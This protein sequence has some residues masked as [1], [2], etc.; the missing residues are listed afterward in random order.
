MFQLPAAEFWEALAEVVAFTA[1]S[2]LIRA[3]GFG[4][5]FRVFNF[6]YSSEILEKPRPAGNGGRRKRIAPPFL[7]LLLKI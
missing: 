5:A 2:R 6:S 3:G 1:I 7:R 4:G